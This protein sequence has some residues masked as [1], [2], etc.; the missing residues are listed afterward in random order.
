MKR[1]KITISITVTHVVT[2][3]PLTT[4]PLAM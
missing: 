1:T 2:D 3:G 4:R